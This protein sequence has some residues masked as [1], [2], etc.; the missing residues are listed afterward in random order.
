MK[1][2]KNIVLLSVLTLFLFA[3]E[4]KDDDLVFDKSSTER[5]EGLVKKYD[6]ILKSSKN[7]WILEYYTG[8]RTISVGGYTTTLRFY[9]D[10]ESNSEKVESYF[11]IHYM[12]G[13]AFGTPLKGVSEYSIV[14]DGGATLSIDTYNEAFHYFSTPIKGQPKGMGQGMDTEFLIT[15]YENEIIYLKG[16][17]YGIEMR[18]TKLKE[19]A[20]D[21]M[22]RTAAIWDILVPWAIYGATP[23]FQGL[24]VG[25]DFIPVSTESLK[26]VYKQEVEGKE[27]LFVEPLVFTDKGLRFYRKQTIN[28]ISFQELNLVKITKDNKTTNI[29]QTEDGKVKLNVQSPLPFDLMTKAWGIFPAHTKPVVSDLFKQKF[30]AVDK[31][32]S[33]QNDN[34]KLIEKLRL[35]FTPNGTTGLTFASKYTQNGSTKGHLIIF[36]LSYSV[37]TDTSIG[38]KFKSN[39]G[40]AEEY[41]HLKPLVNFIE[42]NSPYTHEIQGS[43]VVK[44]ISTKNPDIWFTIY[45]LKSD[46][47]PY[48]PLP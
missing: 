8:G 23:S 20:A 43:N 4:N 37:P 28:G 47:K 6:D 25:E 36:N 18:M 45:K 38:I 44:L 1:T 35:G 24:T 11:I 46:G 41:S 9:N 31:E 16:R 14:E 32:N 34:E 15:K 17:Q 2:I 29:F 26:L 19:P 12:A 27:K 42:K 10:K 33:K 40:K 7:G 22:E 39:G 30:E 3:C 21:Y 13:K 48:E 5:V